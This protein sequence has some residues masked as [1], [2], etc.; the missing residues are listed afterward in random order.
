VDGDDLG[1]VDV[2]LAED[3]A[4]GILAQLI[5]HGGVAPERA[6]LRQDVPRAPKP[7]LVR[8]PLSAGRARAMPG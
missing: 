5:G 4:Q 6:E 1:A 8:R 7:E 3:L 2:N